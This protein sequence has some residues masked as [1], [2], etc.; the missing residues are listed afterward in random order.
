[1]DK[2]CIYLS[3]S[4][5]QRSFKSFT[6]TRIGSLLNVLYFE[7]TYA[8]TD[9]HRCIVSLAGDTRLL[10]HRRQ[11]CHFRRNQRENTSE[12]LCTKKKKK[13]KKKKYIN[14]HRFADKITNRVGKIIS[15][16]EIARIVHASV[17]FPRFEKFFNFPSGSP[18]LPRIRY[19]LCFHR[20]KR[21]IG[22]NF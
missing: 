9:M 15:T 12:T 13:K 21:K 10:L 17:G 6:L 7:P 19:S 11:Q 14:R 20:R 3:C 2:V 16:V 4:S 18:K 5:F 22:F 1:M 8:R